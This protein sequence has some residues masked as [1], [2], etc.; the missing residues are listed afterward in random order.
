MA[1]LVVGLCDNLVSGTIQSEMS[2]LRVLDEDEVELVSGQGAV[3]IGVTLLVVGVVIGVG[4]GYWI[5]R[6]PPLEP[7]PPPP[8]SSGWVNPHSVFP[9]TGY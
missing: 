1:N 9:M 6:D 8:V 4:V 7:P 5:N 3:L 2:D